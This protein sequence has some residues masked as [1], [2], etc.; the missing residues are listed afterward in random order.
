VPPGQA[1]TIAKSLAIGNPADGLRARHR[2]PTGG[3]IEDVTDDEIVEGIR[4][5]PDRGHLR[6]DRRRRDRRDAGQAGRAGARPDE[7]DVALIT[8]DG[9]KT[10]DAV[11]GV[12]GPTATI[13]PSLRPSRP[14]LAA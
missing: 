6:R 14:G 5:S 9:L 8:G 10:L 11:A 12:V 3:A 4:C 2:A 1:D 13:E 7:R